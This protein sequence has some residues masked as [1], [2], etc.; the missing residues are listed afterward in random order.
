MEHPSLQGLIPDKTA[1][2][3]QLLDSARGAVEPPI[4]SEIFG[5]KR[6]AQHGRSLG[7]THRATQSTGR[8]AHFFPRIKSNLIALREAH[9][10][11]GVQ[12][13]TGYDISPAAEWLLDNF[14]LIEAQLTEINA[15]LPR[16]YFLT[17]PKLLDEP[18]AGLPRV[19][20]VAWAFVAHTDGAFD[21]AMLVEFLCAYQQ[22]RELNLSEM[23]ALPTTL[24]V[25]LI[26]SLRRLAERVATNKAAREA[27]NLCFDNID[28]YTPDTLNDLL[29]LLNG[30]GVGRVFLVQLAQRLNDL[31]P[32][33]PNAE[34][35]EFQGW[36]RNA[37]PDL[38]AAQL[39][40]GADQAAD[41]L[42][43]RNAI[44]SLRAIGDAD[45]PDIITRTSVLMQ[46]MLGSPVFEAEDN[47]TR[48]QTL[49]AIERLAK[50]S[51]QSE[52]SVAHNLL[53]LMNAPADTHGGQSVAAHWLRGPGQPA[54]WR[55]LGLHAP[56]AIAW[57]FLA[58]RLVL[59]GYLGILFVT[60]GFLL[61][62]MLRHSTADSVGLTLLVMSLALFPASEAVVAVIH[63]LIS[64]SVRPKHLP[65]L[66]L[67]HG[68]PPEHRVMVVI[69]GMLTSAAATLALV[70][71]LQLHYLA[72]PEPHAQFA[73]LSDWADADSAQ[74]ETDSALLENAMQGVRDLNLKYPRRADEASQAPRFIVLHRMRHFSESEQRWIGWERKRGKLELLVTALAQRNGSA[75]LDLGAASRIEPGT[76]YIVTLD[77]DTQ[78]PPGRLRELVGVAAHPHNQPQLDASGQ[79]IVS[80]YGILQPRV[81]MPLPAVK[82]FTLYHWLFAG[83]CGI[84]PYSA[85][86]SEIYQDLFSEGT[87]TGKGLL[88]VRAM[89][90]VLTNR[91]PQDQ[92][93]S[94]DLLEGAMARC[95]AISDIAVLEDAPFHSDVAASRV[96]RWTRG[97]WQL[98]P[99]LLKPR[100]YHLS[101][102]NLWKLTDNLRRSLVAPISLALLLA[103]LSGL[104]MSPWVALALVMAAFTA[105]PV[106]GAVAG[107]SPSHGDIAKGHFYRAALLDLARALLGGLWLLA[108]LL[109]HSLLALDAIGRALYRIGVSHR[110]LLQWTTAETAQAQASTD[111]RGILRQHRAEP[112][113][114]VS[115]LAVLLWAGTPTPALAI[116]LC[117]LWAASP[118]W[119]WWVS[120]THA[121]DEETKL[122][123][124]ERVYLTGIARDTWR[125]FERCVGPDDRHL[126]PDNLQSTP[127]DMV[128]HR[129]SPTNIG[130]YLLS[131]AC[132][133]QFGWIGTQDLLARLEATLNSLGTL[134]RHR[135]HFMNWYDTQSGEAL[136][137]MYV[138]T[139]DSG[140]LSG[141]LLA[142]AQACRELALSPFDG[143]GQL[144]IGAA[145]A[146]LQP[147]LARRNALSMPERAQ[148][149]WLLADLRASLVSN[150]LDTLA[151][152]D[153][154]PALPAASQRLQTLANALEQLAWQPDFRFLYSRRRHLFHIGYRVAEHQRDA[155]FYDLLASESRLTSLLAIA[156]GDVPVRHWPALGRQ[157][158][159]VGT[160]AGLRSW[161]GSMFE[162]LM[163]GVVLDEPYGSVL[164]EASQA[165]LREQMAFAKA[166]GVPWGISESAYAA[167][168][169]TL[170]YQYAP[171]GVP[172]LALRRTPPDELVVAPYATALV[173]QIAP[174]CACLNFKVLQ[175]LGARGRYGFI[176]ALDYS[177]AGRTGNESFTPVDT[178]MAHH[179]GMSI[180]ALANLLLDG[181]ALRWGMANAHVQA[182]SSLLHERVP[183]EIPVL[184]A[185]PS[186]L[187]P[188]NQRRRAP[189][190]FREVLPGNN[191]IE[192]SHILSNGRYSVLL[193]ANGAGLSRWD[194]TGMTRWRD[195]ALRDAHGS[196]FFVKWDGQTQPCSVTQ[197]PAP[198]PQALYQSVFHADRVSFDAQWSGLQAH[199][200]VWVSP[201]DDI[202]FRQVELRNLSERTLNI[203]LTSAFEVTLSD[204]RADE[205]HPAFTNLFITAQWLASQQALLFERKPRLPSEQ[206]LKVAHFLTDMS[207]PVG[208]I[209]LTT[210]RQ[211]WQGRNQA[212]SHLVAGL[213]P[214]PEAQDD[215][216][217]ALDT[218]LD[219]VCA[220]AVTL[221]IAPGAKAR[222]TFATTASLN[223]QTLRAVIDKYRLTSNVQRASLMSATMTSIRLRALRITAENFAA[224]QTLSTTLALSLTRVQARAVRPK[225]AAT[226]VCDR[227]LLWRFGISGDRPIILVL[228]GVT[229]GLGLLRSLSQ[230]LNLWAWSRQ[231]CDLVVVNAEPASYLMPLQREIAALRDRHSADCDANG[232]QASTGFHLI[233]ANELSHAELG[234][235]HSLA[236]V[237]L[238]ADGRPLAF[239]VQ[240]LNHRH[241]LVR[242][243][244]FDT[245]TSALEM[246]P[247]GAV[248]TPSQGRFVAATG[249]FAFAVS[250]TQR[251]PRPWI[252][253][254][255]NPGFGAQI[256]E[257][258]GGYTWAV[259]SRLNQ[260]TAWSN[261][262]VGDPASEWFLLQNTKTSEV[263]RLSPS[264]GVDEGITFQVSHGQGAS[265]I[266]HRRG[267][268][269]V[270]LSWCVDAQSS[271]KQIHVTLLNRGH[272]TQHL[273]LIGMVEWLMGANRS[274]RGTVRTA[275][276]HQRLPAHAQKLT[277]MLSTQRDAAAGF[278]GGT[279][280]FGMA[281]D[282]DDAED[283]SCDRREFF[284]AR[285][286]LVI[287]DYFGQRSGDGLDPCA[288]LSTHIILDSGSKVTRTFLMGY[289]ESPDAARQLA[290]LATQA[291]AK[292]RLDDVTDSWH[293]LLG[294][295]TVTTPDPLFDAMV[296]HWLLYQAVSCRLWAKA[297][298]YQAGGA[299]GFRDQLQDAMALAWAAPEMLRA[300][301]ILNASRQFVQGDVQHW[302]HEP[303]GNGVRTHF[304]DDLLW[305]A[306]ACVFYL[307]ATGDTA[308][309]DVQVPFL[310]GM[311]IPAGAEDAY[312]APTVSAEQASVFEH[313]A[314][315]IDRSLAVGAHGLPLMGSGDWNDGMN[316][317]GIEG[318]GESVWLGWFL[319]Q[320]VADFAP[321]A[322]QRGDKQRALRWEQAALGWRSALNGTAWDGQWFKR[323]FFDNGQALG[324]K[325]NPEAR[326]DLIA[327]AWSVLSHAAP[328]DRQQMAMAAVQAHLV[329]ANAGLIKL[330]D[331]PLVNAVPSAGYIQAYPPGVRE[332]GGQYSHAGV[333]ALMAQAQLAAQ[334]PD[335]SQAGDLAYRYFTYLSPAHRASHPARG[336]A[337]GLEPYVMAG[338]VYSQAP[339]VGRGGWSWYTGAAAW[340]H[341]AAIESLFGL[342]QRAQ[343]LS[344]TPCLPSHW[345]KAELTLVRGQRSMRFILVRASAADAL[346]AAA[347]P[348]AQ[349]LQAGEALH[350]LELTGSSCFVIPLQQDT[351]P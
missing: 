186:P 207:M 277:A 184:R 280:F 92:V 292:Q 139:V 314:R 266:S 235:L 296:N 257:A 231:A 338:D 262:P 283:W 218:G 133:R 107:L 285:G 279:A 32:V 221:R 255:A 341:R 125:F 240:E 43:M 312:F 313:A 42:S 332:N 127:H 211:R 239:H 45:W 4:R 29:G 337:Y 68:I 284:D 342:S 67:V 270:S 123:A 308:L 11:I 287:P 38:A 104:A 246:A 115:L 41:N 153:L 167:S 243:L 168:D 249:E 114:A 217:V 307:Q 80:G 230:A 258:G 169:F 39:Q 87:F 66:A 303:L 120:R 137:P 141:H 5:P 351:K 60:L 22:T 174:H 1:V 150:R 20:G 151:Q 281:S 216:P 109:Q 291:S 110:H 33:D 185:L 315:A 158:F 74:L 143:A 251:P 46:L 171:H 298:F 310:D 194:Q 105:G 142:V 53:A 334:D 64:E 319:C 98:L 157:F 82:E 17:L 245:S 261:D 106:M 78:L 196:F 134:Q 290:T 190:L 180:V 321:L 191:A 15:G 223:T 209:R 19:Y 269:E 70:N 324:A 113:V 181:A 259:N 48:D 61:W 260:L 237:L 234:T 330:L 268:L 226:E 256:S 346:Q 117:L 336:P 179:Q 224:M 173:A 85:A 119:T 102:I 333:W 242:A 304:S 79:K 140:N 72:N 144:A 135:G 195:D 51:R 183:R 233:P 131:V 241:E 271:V 177:A 326:I 205:A 344:F 317:V 36:L 28:S 340:L 84:D 293:R 44:T 63:R 297:G 305:L 121:V 238:H 199:T 203:E 347:V 286:R 152:S 210:D 170:A 9:H 320:L 311:A 126:P 350:W 145:K 55:A 2:F 213:D 31:H 154:P 54:L 192:P 16:S 225:S 212:A 136:L 263:W 198:D 322:Q 219:P 122:P 146:R 23:W 81:A 103:T 164:H 204:P 129:T 156:K 331:P 128:A 3:Y 91:L 278:G 162:Y 288:A 83:Q 96:H 189:G 248:D 161:T 295:T 178:V 349:L 27:A 276:F 323:A 56:A 47:A 14:H 37:L 166:L 35:D 93:L 188:P 227:R 201:E 182:V 13:S 77:S 250:A 57:R 10:F 73:L 24:R 274:D 8:S 193:R 97:D 89:H 214:A 202:E 300:Q 7:Q 159:A 244:R 272:K 100:R 40:Q 348:G 34:Q 236:R 165:A 289:A 130:L 302:W 206:G 222:L 108:Q 329:D 220:L 229:Q 253:V 273:R 6:F 175:E 124:T 12:A 294:S 101:A 318:L 275:S 335:S 325:D 148:V 99:F 215:L 328:L 25:V 160:R 200:T 345:P 316:R 116:A 94:H 265:A 49:H 327:Q 343:T 21:E 147:L 267:E 65:R 76:P 299:T 247:S 172:R 58:R 75:F 52:L 26:E 187:H 71:R 149:K 264:A 306:H 309:L 176:E 301:I 90:A 95:A 69:P 208:N 254:L 155:G 88:N 232:G 138:S 86:S 228:A 30:R 197:H 112:I 50:R 18:L 111:L 339:Y 132:A 118:L 163:P 282:T 62:L 252:N 59:P